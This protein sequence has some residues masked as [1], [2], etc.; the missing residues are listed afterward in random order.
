MSSSASPK[1][2]VRPV[3]LALI[4]VLAVGQ[5]LFAAYIL[6]L[7]GVAIAVGQDAWWNVVLPNLHVGGRG[8]GNAAMGVHLLAGA[9]VCLAGP[10]QLVRLV[11]SLQGW[12]P[13]IH[14]WNGRLYVASAGI[15]GVAGLAFVLMA[16]TIGGLAMDLGFGL[17]GALMLTA[18]A[19][20]WRY[21]RAADVT[22]HR[23]WA[24]R[25]FVLGASSFL[26]RVG[27]GLWALAAGGLVGHTDTWDG[28]L[29]VVMDFAFYVVPLVVLELALWAGRSDSRLAR[30][31]VAAVLG[32]ASP[33][34]ALGTLLVL[35]N[36][37]LP[38][39]P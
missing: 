32:V 35:L 21:G 14:R 30:G 12:A 33:V 38:A 3:P 27:Y 1:S 17:Y 24:L 19:Q 10:V 36:W 26:Y 11:P 8:F 16:G 6:R 9:I 37:W 39:I 22:A 20:T 31:V 23:T 29:D 4:I 15:V 2:A 7:Y 13:T 18:A 5:A 25:L 34:I 28:P